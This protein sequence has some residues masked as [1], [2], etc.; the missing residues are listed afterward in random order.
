MAA[1]AIGCLAKIPFISKLSAPAW[2]LYEGAYLLFRGRIL[3]QC[4][5]ISVFSWFMECVAGYI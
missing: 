1:W 3:L 5:V 4:F 2:D